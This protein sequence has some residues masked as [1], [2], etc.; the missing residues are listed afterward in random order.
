MFFTEVLNVAAIVLDAGLETFDVVLEVF[1][2]KGKFAA[3]LLDAVDFGEYGLKLVEGFHALL[4]RE[5]FGFLFSS[6]S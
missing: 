5:A 6:H 3:Y 4:Y 1:N 2:L